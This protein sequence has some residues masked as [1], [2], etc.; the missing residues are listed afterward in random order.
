[1][2]HVPKILGIGGIGLIDIPP[3]IIF[4]RIQSGESQNRIKELVL[5]WWR[6]QI[7][8]GGTTIRFDLD[9]MLD[10]PDIIRHADAILDLRRQEMERVVVYTAGPDI[11][12]KTLWLTAYGFRVLDALGFGTRCSREEFGQVEAAL[13][14]VGIDIHTCNDT[15]EASAP[16]GKFLH[17]DDYPVNMS[18]GLA[19]C[20]WNVVD[21]KRGWSF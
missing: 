8:N 14:E 6:K 4:D 12:L 2:Q 3:D 10:R 15:S 16:R 13:K 18:K 7:A 20:I 1:M 9:R 19:K 17:E 11:N 21:R 5:N